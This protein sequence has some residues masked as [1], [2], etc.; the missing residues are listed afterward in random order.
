M[1]GRGRVRIHPL[2]PDLWADLETLFGAR[3]AC[4][5]CW[6]MT[7]RLPRAVYEAAKGEGNRRAFR[8]RVRRGPPPG[9]LAYVD[10]VPAGW[11][12]IAPRDEFPRLDASRVLAR[13][14]E[15]PVWSVACFFV[16]RPYRRRGLSVRLL[17]EACRYARQRGATLV[18]GYPV[19]PVKKDVPPV[20]AWTGLASAFRQ[21]GFAEVERRTETRPIMRRAMRRAT[22]RS[23]RR[24]RATS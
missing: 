21:A 3:G 2:T 6:C 4:G 23:G 18:E 11:C 10:D 7:W 12:A 17:E 9:L 14:D 1:T 19:E 8:R 24:G 22:S 5:G 13:V 16:A 20:F 15:A